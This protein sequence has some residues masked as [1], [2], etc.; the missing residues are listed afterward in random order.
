MNNL[1]KLQP[2]T[3]MNNVSSVYKHSLTEC[4]VKLEG[5]ENL[6]NRIIASNS[7]SE[8]KFIAESAKTLCDELIRELK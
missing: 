1:E 6:L 4:S 7:Q 2:I 3:D 5:I 8:C